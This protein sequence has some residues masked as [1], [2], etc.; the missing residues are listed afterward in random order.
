MINNLNLPKINI[1]NGIVKELNY[2]DFLIKYYNKLK[3]QS[4]DTILQKIIINDNKSYSF[5]GD[6]FNRKFYIYNNGCNDIFTDFVFN[7]NNNLFYK[8]LSRYILKNLS[9]DDV[10]FL[11]KTLNEEANN[12]LIN[13]SSVTYKEGHRFF[14]KIGLFKIHLTNLNI[15]NEEILFN[16]NRTITKIM[17][18]E[19][20]IFDYVEKY[21]KTKIEDKLNCFL[22][23]YLKKHDQNLKLLKLISVDIA[24][25]LYIEILLKDSF[26]ND[27]FNLKIKKLSI[28]LQVSNSLL[29][30]KFDNLDVNE[31]EQV[32]NILNQNSLWGKIVFLCVNDLKKI[33]TYNKP[34][35]LVKNFIFPLC[36]ENHYIRAIKVSGNNFFKTIIKFENYNLLKL[37]AYN[38]SK[39]NSRRILNY[40]IEKICLIANSKNPNLNLIFKNHKTF[41]NALYVIKTVDEIYVEKF[42]LSRIYSTLTYIITNK[43]LN[44]LFYE[45]KDMHKFDA[46][47]FVKISKLNRGERKKEISISFKKLLEEKNAKN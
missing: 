30:S 36:N 46:D 26:A 4:K 37:I 6:E 1:H 14:K 8:E 34:E 33:L 19:V 17:N 28:K 9:K 23:S 18:L 31:K 32:F 27:D 38:S 45:L 12:F 24:R 35:N 5:I 39:I 21:K 11:N 20:S 13:E 15:S 3:T 41:N 16:K 42:I 29:L 44:D 40:I 47:Y 7:I 25:N 2:K 10:E 22:M 43:K